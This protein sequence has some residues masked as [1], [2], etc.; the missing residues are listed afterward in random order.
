M[1]CIIHD[2]Y[3]SEPVPGSSSSLGRRVEVEEEME[4]GTDWHVVLFTHIGN[5]SQKYH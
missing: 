2:V 3:S 1:S 5:Y 4:E